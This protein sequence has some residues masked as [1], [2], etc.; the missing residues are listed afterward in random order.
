MRVFATA[1]SMN[2]R[3]FFHYRK[4]FLISIIIHPIILLVDILLFQT[5]YA[6]N[7]LATLQGYH[8]TEMVWYFAG[9]SFIYIFIWNFTDTRLSDR[10]LSGELS[11][12]LIRPMSV[13]KVELSNAIG[14]R[15]SGLI[16][17][18]I[19]DLIVFS[20]IFFPHFMTIASLLKFIVF[21][22]LAFLIYFMLAFLIGMTAFVTKNNHS[23][24]RIKVLLISFLGGGSVPLEFYP[25]WLNKIVDVLPF[26]YIFYIP[27]QMLLNRESVQGMSFFVQ[28]V[29]IQLAWILLFY[30]L[31]KISWKIMIKKYCAVGG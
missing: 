8:L 5:I 27:I 19:P 1:V 28:T 10:I 23:L 7:G 16:F 2:L 9:I 20:L 4:S 3:V 24:S 25:S 12:D 13:F 17:E 6:H 21:G 31:C 15:M 14:L 11:T 26:K 22:I 29:C 30:V 18:F